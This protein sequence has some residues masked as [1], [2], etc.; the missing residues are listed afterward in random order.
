MIVGDLTDNL[1]SIVSLQVLR[2]LGY[3]VH[4]VSPSMKMGEK[5]HT[6]FH[7]L[8]GEQNYSE[9]KTQ[10]LVLNYDFDAVQASEYYACLE[11]HKRG[12]E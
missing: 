5:V 11:W 9:K 12:S 2:M 6:A 3:E 10:Y 8:E 1:E 4:I 7:D